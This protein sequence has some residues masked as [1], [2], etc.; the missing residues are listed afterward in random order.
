MTDIFSYDTLTWPEV[1]ALPRDTPLVLPL[2]AGYPLP[3]LGAALGRPPRLGMLPA[4]PY[5]WQG[6]ALA[7]PTPLLQA[8]VTNLL[9]SL[10][11]EGFCHAYVLIPQGVALGQEEHQVTLPQTAHSPSATLL[12]P[13]GDRGKVVLLP[14]GHTEQHGYHLPLSTDT[15]IIEAIGA[16]TAAAV[17]A[18]ATCLPV[19]PYGVSTHRAS[20]AGTFNA[21]G[22]VFEDFW[23]AVVDAL[24]ERGF[25]RFYIMTGHGGNCSFLVNVVKYAWG[26]SSTYFLR[27]GLVVHCRAARCGGTATTPALG[28]RG[29]GPC[30]RARNLSAPA[31]AP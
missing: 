17:P 27:H 1:A 11:Q 13:D 9:D 30:W 4:I 29:H 25:D 16:G 20:F 3:Q 24:V 10:R 21:G 8:Y 6:S 2:G 28:T 23:L 19:F 22:R 12:P 31:P 5:G 14:I 18:Q 15:V 7:V 26:A